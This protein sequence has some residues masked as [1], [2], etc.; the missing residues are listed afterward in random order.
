MFNAEKVSICLSEFIWDFEL[1]GNIAYNFKILSILEKSKEADIEINKNYYNKPMTIIL[2]SIIEAI[3]IDMLKRLDQGTKDLPTCLQ[4]RI[5]NEIKDKIGRQKSFK[6]VKN[7][8]TGE[9]HKFLVMKKYDFNVI[10]KFCRNFNLLFNSNGKIY[11]LLDE[12]A[13]LRNRIHIENYHKNFEPN[14]AEVFTEE[15]LSLLK[16]ILNYILKTMMSK[17]S[18]NLFQGQ[19]DANYQTWLEVMS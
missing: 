12:F 13:W 14:E 7:S 16:K 18:R 9:A 10:V 1:G 8:I 15:R 6:E 5:I 19:K 11:D 4:E 2:V 17:Y 3:L